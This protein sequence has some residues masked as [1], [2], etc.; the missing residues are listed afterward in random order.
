MEDPCRGVLQCSKILHDRAVATHIQSTISK[1]YQALGP[2]Q[3]A[4]DNNQPTRKIRVALQRRAKLEHGSGKTE[5]N[6]QH[7][8]GDRP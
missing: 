8:P 2:E 6:H 4:S 1:D 7:Q 3:N 5:S